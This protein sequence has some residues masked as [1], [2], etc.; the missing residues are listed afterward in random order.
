[1]ATHT[2]PRRQANA[3]KLR[4][5]KGIS[6]GLSAALA[7]SLWWLVSNAVAATQAAAAPQT[8][9]ATIVHAERD[10][11]SSFFGEN[12]APSLGGGFGSSSPSRPMLRSGGS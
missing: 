5:L 6:I 2:D 12:Q 7:G 3:D 11:N 4:T 8:T 1:M 10:D 9:P